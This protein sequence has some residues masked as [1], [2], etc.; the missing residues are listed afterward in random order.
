[1]SI[2]QQESWVSDILSSSIDG[3]RTRFFTTSEY[4]TNSISVWLNGLLLPQFMYSEYNSIA[5]DLVD[6]PLVG[7][8][9]EVM[10]DLA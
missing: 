4:K 3:V 9:L 8:T 1:M 2:V 10:Y 5:I 7:D 6:P